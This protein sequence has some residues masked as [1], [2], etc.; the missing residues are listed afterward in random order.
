[1][2]SPTH[3]EINKS[4]WDKWAENLDTDKRKKYQYLRKIQSDLIDII[5]P[6]ENS[7]ILDI[8]CGT[9]QALGFAAKKN[10]GKGDYTGV[11][12]SEKMIEKAKEN[13]TGFDNF[14][15]IVCNAESIPLPGNSFDII[16]C[17]NSFHHYN[18]PVKCLQEMN[19]LLNQNGRLFIVD[20]ASD[21]LLMKII[22]KIISVFEKAHVKMYSTKE[23]KTLFQQ[24]GIKYL[25]SKQIMG[26]VLLHGGEK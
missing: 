5:N 15:F 14:H 3:E 20:P 7:R 23:F 2:E 11:D 26:P 25:Y 1:M 4:K 22:N 10:K 9:G 8:G 19:R 21:S 12:I 13:F 18:H 6:T 16:I 24:A 17:T